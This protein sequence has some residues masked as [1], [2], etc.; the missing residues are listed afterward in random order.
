MIQH[1]LPVPLAEDAEG[2]VGGI[3]RLGHAGR[4]EEERNGER[5]FHFYRMQPE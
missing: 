3:G 4:G 1:F 5:G 2:R